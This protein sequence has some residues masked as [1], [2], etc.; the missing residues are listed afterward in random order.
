M[1]LRYSDRAHRYTYEGKACTSISSLGKMLDST[2]GLEDWKLR[3][4]GVGFV[5]NPD[6][7]D[8]LV[9]HWNEDD[10]DAKAVCNDLCEQAITAAKAKAGA[11][12]GTAIHRALERADAGET[13]L[14]ATPTTLAAIEANRTSLEAAGLTPEPG[15]SEFAVIW[16]DEL[17]AG[18]CDRAYRLATPCGTC[19]GTLVIGDIKS[20]NINYPHAICVQLAGYALAPFIARP[21]TSGDWEITN[22]DPMPEHV[23]RCQAL[24][25]AVPAGST[26][27][28]IHTVDLTVGR[29]GLDLVKAVQGWRKLTGLTTPYGPA[30]DLLE[31]L[32]ASVAAVETKAVVGGTGEIAGGPDKV[33]EPRPK[34]WL[35][36]ERRQ[37]LTTRIGALTPQARSDLA[38]RWPEGTPTLKQSQDHTD[39]QL[40]EINTVLK[41][42][43][44]KHL[45]P[46]P[47]L[48][49]APAADP[50]PQEPR[51][52]PPEPVYASTDAI[53]TMRARLA[54]LD[55]EDLAEITAR[56]RH[57]RFA[58]GTGIPNLKFYKVLPEH[59]AYLDETIDLLTTPGRRIPA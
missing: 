4:V 37:D 13:G 24:I 40:H 14:L 35:H 33:E 50:F 48:P 26:I 28:T 51:V 32:T 19:G 11:N 31:Q 45:I 57:A 44:S 56:A 54:G 58:T 1:K 41:A 25:I 39:E 53:D 36:D 8:L 5:T 12:R 27:G 38:V 42:I 55:P 29:Q 10:K 30:V 46:F 59:L 21:P 15:F 52:V 20:G 7:G 34:V 16:P 6:L 49:P 17:W 9:S 47:D 3:H 23:C 22:F 2:K 43:E 18:R